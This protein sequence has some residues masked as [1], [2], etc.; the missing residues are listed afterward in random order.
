LTENAEEYKGI[1]MAAEYRIQKKRI[2]DNVSG[3]LFTLPS[4]FLFLVLTIV[5]FIYSLC[6]S[7]TEVLPGGTLIDVQFAG[8]KQ[9]L[10]A[11]NSAEFWHSMKVTIEY[12]IPVVF[13]HVSL[14]LF[15]AVILNWKIPGRTVLRTLSFIPY[16]LSTVVVSMIWRFM[17]SPRFGLINVFFGLFGFDRNTPWLSSPDY[18]LKAIILMSIWKWVGYHM[19]IFLAS[20]QGIPESLYEAADM[21]GAGPWHKFSK[22]TFP[23][24]ANTTWF[25][26]IVSVI[27]TFQA[28]DQIYVMTAGG[29]MDATD[30]VVYNMYKNAF[31]YLNL[32][33]ASAVSWLLFV[34]VFTLTLIQN[35]L[36]QSNW[37]Y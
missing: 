26:T 14:G 19:V 34:L 33:Y 22:I 5:P 36:S 29:P 10:R 8:F 37:S 11:L 1:K 23:L 12:T 32:P 15:L 24:L 3:Y 4:I 18:A 31:I 30:V 16:V 7:F 21:E 27:N 6:L 28:F 9:Y 2:S 13:F 25:L 17:L 35:K 20:L